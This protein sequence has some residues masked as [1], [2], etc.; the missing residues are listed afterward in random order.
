MSVRESE[1]FE[2]LMRV[3]MNVASGPLGLPRPRT[4]EEFDEARAFSRY[5]DDLREEM[6]RAATEA[7]P[8]AVV[9]AVSNSTGALARR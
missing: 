6:R 5:L 4:P 8:T 9:G 7:A 2:T 3:G 1:A